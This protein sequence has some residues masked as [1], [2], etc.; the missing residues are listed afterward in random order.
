MNIPE[1]SGAPTP[2]GGTGI[3]RGQP[4]R[5][6]HV[7][8]ACGPCRKKKT[9]CNGQ[10]PICH[11][12]LIA[13][14]PEACSWDGLDKRQG[15]AADIT[16]LQ[17]RVG[18]LEAAPD[19]QR[20]VQDLESTVQALLNHIGSMQNMMPNLQHMSK[21][22]LPPPTPASATAPPPYLPISASKD[23]NSALPQL[24]NGGNVYLP[25]Q[26]APE[27]GRQ[28]SA[29]VSTGSGFVTEVGIAPRLTVQRA[30]PP[31][32]HGLAASARSL[33]ARK[34]SVEIPGFTQPP[35]T[36]A[37][38][39]T[40][41]S[42]APASAM[43]FSPSHFARSPGSQSSNR[44][45]HVP[46]VPGWN[47]PHSPGTP[48]SASSFSSQAPSIISSAAGQGFANPL[49]GPQN[50]M[51]SH[52]APHAASQVPPT[53]A[54]QS[55][56]SPAA[57]DSAGR[58]PVGV[59]GFALFQSSYPRVQSMSPS[60]SVATSQ[61]PSMSPPATVPGFAAAGPSRWPTT[62]H[63]PITPVNGIAGPRYH[64][65]DNIPT[66]QDAVPAVAPVEDN[67]ARHSG[68]VL[69]IEDTSLHDMM[70]YFVWGQPQR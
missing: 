44:S 16:A 68:D 22:N 9:K 61:A 17:E 11:A 39:S 58:N 21:S 30:S 2:G 56:H 29:V 43:G 60:D 59:A 41:S 13:D 57:R 32:G 27:W 47:N 45:L 65:P 20:R 34:L 42:G 54:S 14:T 25:V 38:E 49:R 37:P 53:T 50:P 26:P 5:R 12:C 33:P 23:P 8:K 70:Q 36:P 7:S 15:C 10:R 63:T 3:D 35:L 62:V 6:H 31:T 24:H 4:P 64:L 28:P 18:A 55:L 69:L 51:L 67:V 48:S 46:V 66:A 1:H 52:A 40:P 19:L